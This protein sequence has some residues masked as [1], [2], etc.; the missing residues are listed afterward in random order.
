MRLKV[1]LPTS[2]IVDEEVTKIIAEAENGYFC[3]LPRH[4]DYVTTLVP[5]ILSFNPVTG[6]SAEDFLAVDEG[7]LIK[8]GNDVTVSVGKAVR[9]SNLGSL[10]KT[11][12][13]EFKNLDEK[14]VLIRSVLAKLETD[15]ARRLI[16]LRQT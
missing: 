12:E 8:C 15:F 2:V 4:I 14:E 3:L 10:K 16:Q 1:L 11:I 7:T 9:S 13:N 5:G 6:Q